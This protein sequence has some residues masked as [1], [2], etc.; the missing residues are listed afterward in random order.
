MNKKILVLMI[1]TL[2]LVSS[3]GKVSENSIPENNSKLFKTTATVSPNVSNEKEIDNDIEVDDDKN[4]KDN[5]DEANEKDD[6][7]ETNDDLK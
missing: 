3:C 6:D 1:T 5:Q 2:S 7:K 4:N